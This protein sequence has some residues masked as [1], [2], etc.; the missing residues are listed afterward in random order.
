MKVLL[1]SFYL[2][3]HTLGLFAKS[4]LCMGVGLKFLLLVIY[5]PF[6]VDK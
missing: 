4:T 1:N 2:N 3:A 5:H 6:F